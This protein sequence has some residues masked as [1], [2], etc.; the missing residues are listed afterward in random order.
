MF[1]RCFPRQNHQRKS[2]ILAE[3]EDIE[4]IGASASL[5]DKTRT[6]PHWTIYIAWTCE[7]HFE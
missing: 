2:S 7:Y 1:I 6:F 5:E 4:R 3:T